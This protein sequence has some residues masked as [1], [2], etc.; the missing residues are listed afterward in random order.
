MMSLDLFIASLEEQE[1]DTPLQV[2]CSEISI[3]PNAES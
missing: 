2:V 3:T 1:M